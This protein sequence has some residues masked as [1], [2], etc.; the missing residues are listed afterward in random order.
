MS[1]GHEDRGDVAASDILL[2]DLVG[3]ESASLIAAI[4]AAG[5]ETIRLGLASG[6]LRGDPLED[7]ARELDRSLAARDA[8]RRWR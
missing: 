3:P 1:D 2:A 7:Y 5:L 8:S 6:R 4:R